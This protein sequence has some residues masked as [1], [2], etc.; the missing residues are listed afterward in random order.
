GVAGE[1]CRQGQAHAEKARGAQPQEVTA[2]GAV[3]EGT[4]VT[5]KNAPPKK[6]PSVY[7]YCGPAG[8]RPAS[9]NDAPAPA[10]RLGPFRFRTRPRGRTMRRVA[11]AAGAPDTSLGTRPSRGWHMS[12]T[13]RRGLI[14]VEVLLLLGMAVVLLG[15]LLAASAEVREA[16]KRAQCSNNLKQIV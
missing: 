2:A 13:P 11:P 1:Q 16:A 9:T 5:H 3:A 15:L 4:G 7:P 10:P 12:P 6:P 8:G 14:L